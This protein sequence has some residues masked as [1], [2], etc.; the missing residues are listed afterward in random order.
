MLPWYISQQYIP[1]SH[2]PL[3][4]PSITGDKCPCSFPLISGGFILSHLL[5]FPCS[6]LGEMSPLIAQDFTHWLLTSNY[7]P[8]SPPCLCASRD[9]CSLTHLYANYPSYYRGDANA[10]SSGPSAPSLPLSA[11]LAPLPTNSVPGPSEQPLLLPRLL[12]PRLRWSSNSC[13]SHQPLCWLQLLGA[14]LYFLNNHFLP[15]FTSA[16]LSP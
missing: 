3:I 11:L 14:L 10:P 12:P 13:F 8:P 15:P 7:K 4:F 5:P 2:L 1:A 9:S 6:P 16:W